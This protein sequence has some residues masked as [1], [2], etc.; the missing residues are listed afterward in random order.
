MSINMPESTYSQMRL[1]LVELGTEFGYICMEREA[2]TLRTLGKLNSVGTSRKA[3]KENSR[4]PATRP[5][6][7]LC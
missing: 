1:A 6:P 7:L 5:P 2:R 3:L 4:G